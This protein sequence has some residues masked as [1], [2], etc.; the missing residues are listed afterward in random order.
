MEYIFVQVGIAVFA[1]SGVLSASRQRLDIF[2]IVV[3][4]LLTALGGGTLRDLILDVP[5]TWLIDLTPFWVA[6]WAACLTFLG[7]RFILKLP[8]RLLA[9]LDAL[10]I[11]LFAIQAIDKTLGLGHSAT[12][13]VVMGLITSIA[14]GII[15]DVVTHRPTLL[16]SRELYATPI[17]LGGML[18]IGLIQVLP[19]PMS[20][21]I[22]MAT[23]FGMRAAAIRWQLFLPLG[24]TLKVN[25]DNKD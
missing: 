11:A 2:S 6:V 1:T 19:A 10:G 23:I 13:A 9:Y 18:Y 17:L 3:V 21:L 4:G 8:R 22:A 24:L 12:V 20:R 25:W 5:V 14:G 7:I 16:L 15:R